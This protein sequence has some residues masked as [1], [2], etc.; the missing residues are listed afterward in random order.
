M[1]YRI[2]PNLLEIMVKKRYV[3]SGVEDLLPNQVLHVD[4]AQEHTLR[5]DTSKFKSG[6][7]RSDIISGRFTIPL[8]CLDRI[9]DKI[10]RD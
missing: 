10:Q 6:A 3:F 5:L 8:E 2:L 1:K 7:V 9:P 4:E